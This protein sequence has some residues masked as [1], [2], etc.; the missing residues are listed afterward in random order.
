MAFF[1]PRGT[2]PIRSRLLESTL[3]DGRDKHSTPF[4]PTS[5]VVRDAMTKNAAKADWVE[6]SLTLRPIRIEQE[7]VPVALASSIGLLVP[8]IRAM[9]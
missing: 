5:E 4:D 9:A 2:N 8:R 3:A 7:G 6:L 1:G